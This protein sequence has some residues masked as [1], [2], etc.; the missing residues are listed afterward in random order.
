MHQSLPPLQRLTLR[1]KH[2]YEAEEEK[3]L[4]PYTAVEAQD[5]GK[6]VEMDSS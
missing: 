5:E 6:V 4:L 3:L 2:I 1:F